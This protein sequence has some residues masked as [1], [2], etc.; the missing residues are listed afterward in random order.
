M[1]MYKKNVTRIRVEYRIVLRREHVVWV[2]M[3]RDS[4]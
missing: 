3:Q 1:N 2:S 4:N